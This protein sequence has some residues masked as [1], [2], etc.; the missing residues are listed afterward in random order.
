MK[1]ALSL[2]LIFTACSLGGVNLLWAEAPEA[3]FAQANRLYAEG[4]YEKAIESYEKLR[5]EGIESGNLFYNLGNAYYKGGPKG[6]AILNYERAKKWI[7]EDGDLFA[8]VNFVSSLLASSQPQESF[9]W[10]EKIYQGLRDVISPIGWLFFSL[11]VY[12]FLLVVWWM[13]IVSREFR[14]RLRV[15]LPVGLISL[16]LPV[17]FFVQ[18]YRVHVVTQVGVVVK[19]QVEVRYTPFKFSPCLTDIAC[20]R[21]RTDRGCWK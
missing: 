19:P 20:L 9:S 16:I 14:R 5:A 17:F 2:L 13:A 18:S 10:Y 11:F 15:L 12:L 1:K 4:S 7:P 6:K 8:N 3:V 21:K